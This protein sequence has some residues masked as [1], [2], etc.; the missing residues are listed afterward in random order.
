MRADAFF[1][2]GRAHTVCQDYARAGVI[3]GTNRAYAVVSDGCSSSPDTDFGSRFVTAAA[4]RSLPVGGND[5]DLGSVIWRAKEPTAGFIPDSCLDATLLIAFEHLDGK[6]H[7]VAVGDGVILARRRSGVVCEAWVIEMGGV[8]G[9]LSYLLDIQRFRD[10]V[11][12]G[13]GKRVT[14]HYV[15]GVEEGQRTNQIAVSDGL[16]PTVDNL[17]GELVFDPETYDLV[18][19]LS[20]GVQSFRHMERGEAV[21][22]LSVTPHVMDIRVLA[23]EFLQRAHRFF[24]TKTCPKLGWQHT[25]DFGAAAIYIDPP[26]EAQP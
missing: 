10:Y 1:A 11:R 18:M 2:I 25:D 19:V 13:Y 12:T 16:L 22:V 21:P 6:V 14:T 7:V 26:K 23:G 3:P 8:P 15:N 4:I 9:Y 5:F 20:D 24:L 17:F